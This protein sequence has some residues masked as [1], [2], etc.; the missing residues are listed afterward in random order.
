[1]ALDRIKRQ[2]KEQVIS[3]QRIL[4]SQASFPLRDKKQKTWDEAQQ[5]VLISPPGDSDASP[6]VRTIVVSYLP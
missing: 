2:K 4:K 3:A 6:S 5:P 1:M